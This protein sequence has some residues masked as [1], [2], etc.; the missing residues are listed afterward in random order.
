MR[1]K[2]SKRFSILLI[3]SALVLI[4]SIVLA[5]AGGDDFADYFNS[6]FAPETSNLPA[7]KPFFRSVHTFYG[8]GEYYYDNYEKNANNIH[9]MDSVNIED[10]KTFFSGKVTTGDLKYIVYKSRI[11]EID[12]CIFYL[13]NNTYVIKD[14]LKNNGLMK[15]EDKAVVK[16]FLFYQGFAKRCEPFAT[17]QKIWWYENDTLDPRKD[18]ATMQKLIS[19]GQKSLQSNKSAFI[20]QRYAFQII[21]LMYQ[22]GMHKEAVAYFDENNDLFL[23]KI[24][25]YYRSLGYLAASKYKL[26]NFSEANYLYSII[27]DNCELMK[28]SSYLSF[29]PQNESDWLGAMNLAKTQREK[30]VLWHLLGIHVDPFRAMTEIYKLDPKSEFLDLLLVRAVNINE[31]EFIKNQSYWEAKEK[32]NAFNT[33]K[34]DTKMLD[35]IEKV[36]TTGNTSKPYLWHLAAGYLNL[37][38]GN[39]K[40]AETYFVNAESAAAKDN[41]VAEQI[42]AF[43]LISMIEQYTKPNTKTEEILSKELSW[44][45]SSI[46]H[47]ALRKECINN[48]ALSRLS[49]KYQAWGDSIKAQCLDNNRNSLFYSSKKNVDDLIAFMDKPAKTNFETFILGVYPYKKATLIN[50]KAIDLIYKYKFEDAIAMIDICP[51]AGKA[52]L[53]ADPFVIHIND[54]HDCDFAAKK[55]RVYT[56][57]TFLKRLVELQK[58][59]ETE[60]ENAADYYFKLANG[61]YNM[62]FFGN[63]HSVFESPLINLHVGYISWGDDDSE[64]SA[65]RPYFDCSKA[66]EYYEKA[67]N[68]STDNEF[69]AKCCFMA[70]KCEQ[71]QYYITKTFTGNNILK[72]GNY[73]KQLKNNFSKTKYYQEVINEC[74]YFKKYAMKK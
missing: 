26:G 70:S 16:D 42:K 63:A 74:G 55:D 24:T 67:I 28:K 35:F 59:A 53:P 1:Q 37:I 9:L 19:G 47:P 61:L 29:H 60:P 17:Y 25:I 48:W 11:G 27:F 13:K 57:Y 68:A 72:N 23:P 34:V 38:R 31:E 58:K 51:D 44:I 50:Y 15:Y 20:K 7:S 36:A 32:S 43:R 45:G 69:K 64:I 71:N 66:M 33:D 65:Y 8:D 62:T 56:N 40:P 54:C 30:E 73:F 6:F 14:Y 41:L 22:A 39:Y 5:C 21:R 10:W 46:H 52:E 3:S 4:T 12:T 49:E 18:L 2:I